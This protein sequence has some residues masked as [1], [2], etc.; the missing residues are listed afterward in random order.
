MNFKLFKY[1]NYL[2]LDVFFIS[3]N[4]MRNDF[5][6]CVW[7][8]IV[9]ITKSSIGVGAPSYVIL[10]GDNYPLDETT[11]IRDGILRRRELSTRCLL[12]N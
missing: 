12:P 1:Y 10:I 3:C 2:Q 4:V 5:E 11:L 6:M 8:I 7:K 9:I